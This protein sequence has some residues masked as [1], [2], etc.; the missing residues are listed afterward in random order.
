M[1]GRSE[2]TAVRSKRRGWIGGTLSI[3][4]AAHFGFV[5]ASC[6]QGEPVDDQTHERE[7]LGVNPHTAPSI[8]R[9]LQQLDELRPLPFER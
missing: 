3:L 9:I 7:E 1:S 6:G 5:T 2:I 8:A 4:A